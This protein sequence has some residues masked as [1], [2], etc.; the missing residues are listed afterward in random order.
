MTSADLRAVALV[1]RQT[2]RY[3]WSEGIF[4]DCL[5]AGYQAIVL[6]V[7]GVLS[8]YAIMSI[9]AAEAHILNLC[10]HPRTQRRG[11]GRWLL[12]VLLDN[13]RD[14][15]VDRV[16]LEVR[17]SNQPALALYAQEGFQ[18]IGIR[19]GYY[20]AEGGREDAVILA[21]SLRIPE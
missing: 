7:D 11:Y 15:A 21:A 8:G 14:S 20:Q 17:P 16:F 3:P 18:Q 1:E 5:L 2:Y 12:H 4:R 9:A 10:L 13:A 19:P 6:D